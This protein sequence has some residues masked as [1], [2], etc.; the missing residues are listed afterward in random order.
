MRARGKYGG[1]KEDVRASAGG[2]VHQLHVGGPISGWIGRGW[3]VRCM[4]VVDVSGGGCCRCCIDLVFREYVLDI[5]ILINLDIT[6]GAF[7]DMHTEKYDV[8][9][10]LTADLFKCSFDVRDGVVA[11][12]RV[13]SG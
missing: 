9:E 12:T 1:S 5:L 2:R 4:I 10:R 8:V 6:V 13:V 3:A 11:E 7:L